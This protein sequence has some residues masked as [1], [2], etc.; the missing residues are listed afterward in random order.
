[1][2]IHLAGLSRI[3]VG[4]ESGSDEVLKFIKKGVTA[5][6]HV[7]A[8]RK[9]KESGISLSEYVILGMG[10][11]R[12]TKEHALETANVLNQINP[13]FIRLRTL[14][15]RKGIAMIEKVETGE[16]ELLHEDDVV[17][18]EMS[19]IS[20]LD[21]ITSYLKS[22][23]ALNLL[24]EVE[25]RLPEDKERMLA[26][27]N[28]YLLLSAEDRLNFRLGKRS[29]I[30]LYLS[31]MEDTEKYEY[32]QKAIAEVGDNDPDKIIEHLKSQCL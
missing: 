14:S 6:Q 23:H 28:R 15:M 17:R 27:T 2:E 1:K 19:L 16:F 3:H 5:R 12:W 8:G 18:E 4:L 7:E 22:D 9:V 31:D 13:N 32:V 11:K 21:G 30:Y 20:N 25:G 10:G 26:I 24:Q 29:N